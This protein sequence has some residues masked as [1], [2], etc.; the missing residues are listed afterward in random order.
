MSQEDIIENKAEELSTSLQRDSQR[1]RQAKK[2]E[3]NWNL[4][5]KD[6]SVTKIAQDW[7]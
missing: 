2:I 5:F 3:L 4:T 6:Y 1:R 7:Q